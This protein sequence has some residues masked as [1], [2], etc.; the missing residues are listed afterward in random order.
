[1]FTYPS[2]GLFKQFLNR[3]LGISY[4]NLNYLKMNTLNIEE[5]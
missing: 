4:F 3:L 5:I 1:M 2:L